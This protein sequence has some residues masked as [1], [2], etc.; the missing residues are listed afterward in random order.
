MDPAFWYVLLFILI[1]LSSFFSAAETAFTGANLIRLKAY[2]EEGR[3]GAKTALELSERFEEVLLVALVMN[4]IVNFSA[5]GLATAVA[6]QTFG[7]SAAVFATLI[8]TFVMII[9]SEILPK[10]YAREHAEEIVL[11]IGVTFR[12]LIFILKPIIKTVGFFKQ[13]F[14]KESEDKEEDPSVTEEDLDVII[15][16]MEEEGVL[17]DAEAN[18][19]RD[20]LD[21]NETFVKNIMTPRIDVVSLNIECTVE[22]AKAVYFQHKF[23]R[24]PIYEE[25]PDNVV[26][27]MYEREFLTSLVNDPSMGSF[28]HLIKTPIYVSNS[29]RVSGLLTK[30]Q[31]EKHHMAIVIDEHGA[32][33]G[34]VTLEDIF[35]EV[36]GEIYDEHDEEELL[37]TKKSDTEYEVSADF[38]LDE[39]CDIFDVNINE[40]DDVVPIGSW[41]YEKLE[42]IPTTGDVY[43]HQNLEFKVTLVKNRR[44]M[45]ILVK[46]L[47]LEKVQD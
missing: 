44:I 21:L 23:S 29:M 11:R 2:F 3:K 36:V 4:N 1:L 38:A 45:K 24:I 22:E 13:P 30:L 28:A 10:S 15:N 5:A 19:I 6:M 9:F 46:K 18:M 40:E 35:E 34:V 17:E 43:V 39:L 12:F 8:L 31:N 32:A 27:I 41:L 26:G 25:A 33:A 47:D 37:I 14:G 20:V 42:D 16:T 7:E